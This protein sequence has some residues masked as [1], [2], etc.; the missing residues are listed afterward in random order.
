MER[1]YLDPRNDLVFKRIFGEHP[2]ILRSF[3]NALLPLPPDGQIVSLEYL[4]AEQTPPIPLLK[5]SIVDVRCR[6]QAG[7]Q[8]IVEMQMNWTSAFLQR[9][10]FNAS[11]AYVRQLEKGERF[12]LL[13][14][15]I[16]L[17]VLDDVFDHAGPEFYHHYQ[18]VNV[19]QPERTI[20]GLQLVFIE[21]PKFRAET[22]EPRLRRA[23]LRFLTTTG[24]ADTPE[25]VAELHDGLAPEAPEI[26]EALDLARESGFSL[27]ELEAYDRY[28]DAVR[29]E[30]TLMSGKYAEGLE[31]GLEKGRE[32]GR[33]DG[34][35]EALRRLL[36]SGM[37]EAEARALLGLG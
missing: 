21:L 30:R 34:L 8:F 29:V 36:D 4:P 33:E 5:N 13:Q 11:K 18:M 6:D 17:S 32:E 1:R 31:E 12:E 27:G 2:Q 20:D 7:R 28:W 15:V 9:V 35:R 19:Q 37:N 3:L 23:W 26:G 24:D 25:E 16:G 14:P 22:V 10:L